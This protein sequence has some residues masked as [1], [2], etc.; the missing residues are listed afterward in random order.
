[1]RIDEKI[2]HMQND[3]KYLTKEIVQL[4]REIGFSFFLLFV[5]IL[6]NEITFLCRLL[7]K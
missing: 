3:I 6:I 5:I 2:E 1:M 4:K 7:W